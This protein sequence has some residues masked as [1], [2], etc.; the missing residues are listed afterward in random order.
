V[1]SGLHLHLL[2]SDWKRRQM[3]VVGVLKTK[4]LHFSPILD[5]FRHSCQQRGLPGIS[6][7]EDESGHARPTVQL[8]SRPG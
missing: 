8:L 4:F 1:V 2:S 7:A 6:E 5:R 3:L